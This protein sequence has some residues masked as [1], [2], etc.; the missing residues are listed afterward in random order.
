MAKFTMNIDPELKEQAAELFEQMGFNMTTAITV[1]LKQSVRD[2]NLPFQP[3]TGIIP[4][5][6]KRP[7]IDYDPEEEIAKAKRLRALAPEH[8]YIRDW[9]PEEIREDL[10]NRGK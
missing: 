9:G 8:S 2:G 3:T 5:K 4:G 10:S 1:F 6:H 7:G